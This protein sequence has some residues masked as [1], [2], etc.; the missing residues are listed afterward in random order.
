MHGPPLVNISCRYWWLIR[1]VFLTVLTRS[2]HGLIHRGF[3]NTIARLAFEYHDYK[4]CADR[5]G[6]GSLW[7]L[8]ETRDW[9]SVRQ[10]IYFQ[11]LGLRSWGWL[12]RRK[13][14]RGST[15]DKYIHA[16]TQQWDYILSRHPHR[17]ADQSIRPV[18]SRWPWPPFPSWRSWL[19]MSFPPLSSILRYKKKHKKQMKHNKIL[20]SIIN[21]NSNNYTIT[22]ENL[23]D[24]I[25]TQNEIKTNLLNSDKKYRRMWDTSLR[26]Y[27]KNFNLERGKWTDLI[28]LA[29]KYTENNITKINPFTI[30]ELYVIKLKVV[31][32]LFWHDI[33]NHLSSDTVFKLQL[34]LNLIFTSE[35]SNESQNLNI[36]TRCTNLEPNNICG[37]LPTIHWQHRN[38]QICCN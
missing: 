30:H 14:K 12:H 1:R 6:E 15:S 5:H 32:L 4:P 29:G 18:R 11:V 33:A 31:L 13:H 27:D 20:N 26:D 35:N 3:G 28:L 7:F 16:R 17:K 37:V 34:K 21:N 2:K 19:S 9:Y 36:T 38:F 8:D 10:S 22:L 24:K 25:R 23:L